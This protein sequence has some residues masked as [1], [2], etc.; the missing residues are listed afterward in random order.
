M[1]HGNVNQRFAGLCIQFIILGKPTVMIE[2]PESSLHDPA[3]GQDIKPLEVI[4]AFDNCQLPVAITIDPRHKLSGIPA[5]RPDDF[6][7]KKVLLNP[8]E[9][10]PCSASILNVGRMN[11]NQ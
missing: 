3:L 1:G 8:F 4:G 7:F 2:P 10:Q 6:Q 11:N 9:Y 5:V